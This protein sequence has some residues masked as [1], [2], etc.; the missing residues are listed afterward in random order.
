MQRPLVNNYAPNFILYELSSPFL[1]IH[2]CCDKL[3]LTGSRLQLVNGVVLLT[4]FL[5]CRLIWGPW[6]SFNVTVDVIRAY[7]LARSDPPIIAELAASNTTLTDMSFATGPASHVPLWLVSVYVAA[8][9]VLN[10]LNFYWFTK[11]ITAI[12]K[13][14]TGEKS[15]NKDE[16]G[17][18]MEEMDA[19]DEVGTDK[20][21]ITS[22][23]V[24][25]LQVVEVEKTEIRKRKG[26]H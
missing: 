2:W 20:E 25:G 23:I 26:R 16:G 18:L 14:F 19:P 3:N 6:Q 10:F 1:N 24:D 4:T 7:Y 13:R 11:M 15:R 21:K 12:R 17:V 9:V 8:N 5:F 22:S